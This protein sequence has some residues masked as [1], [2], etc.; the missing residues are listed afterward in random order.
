MVL[1]LSLLSIEQEQ[2]KINAPTSLAQQ[3]GIGP[4]K[5]GAGA[6]KDLDG[7]RQEGDQ[8]G[9]PLAHLTAGAPKGTED[10]VE[11]A[12]FPVPEGTEEG[13]ALAVGG[14]GADDVEGGGEEGVGV[15]V[16]FDGVADV[17]HGWF[18]GHGRRVTY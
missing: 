16:V 5:A 13:G 8:L 1:F 6:G 7:G 12:P 10:G 3:F 4:V 18:G 2:D 17:E 14:V 15:G 9:V 11:V